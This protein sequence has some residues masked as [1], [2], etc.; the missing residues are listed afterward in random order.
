MEKL[1][2]NSKIKI[3]NENIRGKY[4]YIYIY[5]RKK[6]GRTLSYQLKKIN[7]YANDWS[8]EKNHTVIDA[9]LQVQKGSAK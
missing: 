2:S 1:V 7:R 5:W 9:K 6:K 4:I 8:K 3:Y